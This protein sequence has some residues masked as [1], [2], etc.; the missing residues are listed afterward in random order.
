MHARPF[1]GPDVYLARNSKELADIYRSLDADPFDRDTPRWHKALPFAGVTWE[2]EIGGEPVWIV[3]IN[4]DE[5]LSASEVALTLV[6]EAVHIKQ[7]WFEAIG[8]SK[9]G[10][11]FEAYTVEQ[12][13]KVLFD[14]WVRP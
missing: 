14:L 6:H 12:I 11:E 1:V 2:L 7:G 4:P 9:P 5:G 3:G 8:E 13:T 10:Y